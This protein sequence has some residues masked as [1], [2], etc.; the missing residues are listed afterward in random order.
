MAPLKRLLVHSQRSEKRERGSDLR[1]LPSLLLV[2]ESISNCREQ[3]IRKQIGNA[4][5][6]PGV[7]AVLE[8]RLHSGDYKMKES[9]LP[10]MRSACGRQGRPIT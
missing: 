7:S 10:F 5:R 8:S 2:A 1:H 6:G 3:K 9:P 4:G